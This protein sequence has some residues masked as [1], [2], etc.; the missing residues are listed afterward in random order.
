MEAVARAGATPLYGHAT[1]DVVVASSGEVS[2]TLEEASEGFDSW[3]RETNGMR[4][5]IARRHVRIAPGARGI[6]VRVRIESRVQF[7]DGRDPRTV[8]PK[9]DAK[10]PA[11]HETKTQITVQLPSVT[12]GY[13]GKTCAAGVHVGLDG[14]SIV[15]GCSPENAGVPAV[16]VVSGRVVGE[17]RL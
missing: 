16:R 11:L 3:S 1:F 7:A 14:V 4:D 8:G 13:V 5:A 10:G 6:R 2:V 15:G 9:V 12:A 17:S